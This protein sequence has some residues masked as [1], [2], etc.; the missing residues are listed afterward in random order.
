MKFRKK[1]VVVEA[2][3]FTQEIVDGYLFHDGKLPAGVVLR[4]GSWSCETE[5]VDNAEFYIPALGGEMDVS[6]GDWIITSP[7][8]GRFPCEPGIFEKTYEPVEGG[9]E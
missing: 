3:R 9:A 5:I 8:G 7:I 4:R 6:V 1:P 2:V